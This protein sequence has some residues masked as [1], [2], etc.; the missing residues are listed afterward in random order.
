MVVKR[1]YASGSKVEQKTVK[2][3]MV[4]PASRLREARVRIVAARA[5]TPHI[6]EA[7]GVLSRAPESLEV[8]HLGQNAPGRAPETH[9]SNHKNHQ[10]IKRNDKRRDGHRGVGNYSVERSLPEM[11]R[12][13]NITAD[14]SQYQDE[15]DHEAGASD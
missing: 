2:D 8:N 14:K 12:E 9:R 1:R 3:Q 10:T 5:A 15:N 6:T 7:K 13:Q 4:K 11:S